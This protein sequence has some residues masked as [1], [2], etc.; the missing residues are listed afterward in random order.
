[1][2]HNFKNLKIWQKSMD[3]VDLAYAFCDGLPKNERYNLIDQITRAACSI[4]SNI[5]EGSG[6]AVNCNLQNI[7]LFTFVIVRIRDTIAYLLTQKV[8]HTRKL[9]SMLRVSC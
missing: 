1:M 4:P 6:N 5:A 8:W 2:E 3:L 7:F 9:T